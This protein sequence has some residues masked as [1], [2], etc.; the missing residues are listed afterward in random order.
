[1][2]VGYNLEGIMSPAVQDFLDKMLNCRPEKEAKINEIAEIYPEIRNIE[3]PDRISDNVTLST[4]HGCPPEEIEKIAMYLVEKRGFH[5]TIKLNP[6]LL[7]PEMLR[8]ILNEKLGFSTIVPDEAFEHDLKYPDALPIIRNVQAASEKRNLQFALKLTNTLESVNSDKIFPAHEKMRYMS[9]RALHPV[10][11]NLAAKLQ[12]EFEGSLD[13]SFSAGADCFNFPEIL[14][15][16]LKPVT[17]SSDILK[18]GGY[19]RLSQYM[20]NLEKEMEVLNAKSLD[21]LVL[22]RAEKQDKGCDSVAKAALLN[23]E[24]YAALVLEKPASHKKGFSGHALKTDRKLTR[25]DCVKAPCMQ[26][27][28]VEQEIPKYMYYAAIADDEKAFDMILHN[29]PLPNVCGLVCD[30]KCETRCTRSNYDRPLEIRGIKNFIASRH[31]EKRLP[32]Q[33]AK[34]GKKVAIIGAGPSGLSCAWFLSLAGFEVQIYEEKAGPGGM[35]SSAIPSFRLS[36]EAINKDIERIKKLGVKISFGAKVDAKRFSELRNKNDY[37]YVS[38]GAQLAKKAGIAGE[39]EVEMPDFLNFLAKARTE[40]RPVVGREV[41]VI[42]GGNSAVDVA[43]AALRLTGEDGRVTL[44]Y[45]RTVQEMPADQEEVEALLQE[46]IQIMELT[47]PVSIKNGDAGKKILLCQKMRLGE[48]DASGRRRPEPVPESDFELSFDTVIAAVGQERFFGVEDEA[49]LKVN[50]ESCET[51]MPGVFVGGDF[52]RGPSSIIRAAADGRRAAIGIQ[53]AANRD[54]KLKPVQME[55]VLT[56]QER[57]LKLARRDFGLAGK[58]SHQVPENPGFALEHVPLSEEAVRKEAS[59]C[60]FCDDVCNICVTVC[61][62]RANVCYLSEPFECQI[63]RAI[64]DN[65]V[66]SISKAGY[67][68]INQRVQVLNIGDFCNECGNC[69]TFCPSAGAPFRDK[70]KFYLSE[71]SFAVE[72][73]GYF[74]RGNCLKGRFDGSLETVSAAENG[75]LFYENDHISASFREDDLSI[76]EVHFKEGAVTEFVFERAV[77]M[78]FLFKSLRNEFFVKE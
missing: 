30:H 23:L 21:E 54:F 37:V 27:C 14:A 42:G 55:K 17:V 63:P 31:D 34:N 75:F 40:D 69:T 70:P 2:S 22:R 47:A 52:L 3:I 13:I 73:D 76:D 53:K 41:A 78:I 33:A 51:E 56:M 20:E 43:R 59:R 25:F 5:T 45:R 19:G 44:V 72:T 62:N 1:M 48:A 58:M 26:T 16:G 4:M 35:L 74:F 64:V 36:D 46:K 10:S 67:F 50:E 32:M 68:S 61:P 28:P 60:L 15:C 11:I 29:N 6:T 24:N 38:V 49:L 18:P 7:G 8:G 9:G 39:D 12:K 77:Q 57:Q 71:D 65:G 66:V